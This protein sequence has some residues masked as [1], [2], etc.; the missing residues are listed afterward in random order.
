MRT[1]STST[2]SFLLLLLVL[3]S[4][5]AS[6]N[7]HVPTKSAAKKA[8]SHVWCSFNIL[9]IMFLITSK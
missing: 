4:F 6:D 8:C 3:E 7:L 1:T 2:P 5:W 9:R